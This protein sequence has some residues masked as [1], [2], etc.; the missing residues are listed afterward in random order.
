M[1]AFEMSSAPRA[2]SHLQRMYFLL[3]LL[4]DLCSSGFTP[5]D[6]SDLTMHP[7][8]RFFT[9]RFGPAKAG[10]ACVRARGG[11]WR[12]R[13]GSPLPPP[14]LRVSESMLFV[15]NSIFCPQSSHPDHC[16]TG[17]GR[18]SGKEGS[19]KLPVH[20]TADSDTAEW[21][22]LVACRVAVLGHTMRYQLD[23]DACNH[24]S[25]ASKRSTHPTTGSI[26]DQHP[27]RA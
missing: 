4:L 18:K 2:I 15:Q 12:H 1:K 5:V 10:F 3:L 21:R 20:E 11:G 14:T 27:T 26:L 17:P 9:G 23:D 24:M 6:V 8:Q 22:R 16:C 13:C 25:R 19:G 7:K